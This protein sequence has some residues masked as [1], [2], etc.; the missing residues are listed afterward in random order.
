MNGMTTESVVSVSC[1]SPGPADAY[2]S[3]QIFTWKPGLML[4]LS[5]ITMN[6]DLFVSCASQDWADAYSRDAA[7]ALLPTLLSLDPASTS[8]SNG[9]NHRADESTLALAGNSGSGEQCWWD[10]FVSTCSWAAS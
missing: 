9:S 5:D 2:R 8:S 1:T 7:A 4:H 6:T 10:S 3:L